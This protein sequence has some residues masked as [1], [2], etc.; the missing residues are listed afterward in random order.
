MYIEAMSISSSTL[1][2]VHKKMKLV[3]I[4]AYV[5]VFSLYTM[6]LSYINMLPFVL[7]Q[8]LYFAL[9]M[10]QYFSFCFMYR[11]CSA[12]GDVW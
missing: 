1:S 3:F 7:C 4:L 2:E 9:H 8:M 10:V 12:I 11:F 6:I 5:Q